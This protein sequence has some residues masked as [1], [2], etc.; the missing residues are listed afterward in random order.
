MDT[1]T[2]PV[3][4]QIGD[5]VI[6]LQGTEL[7]SFN[8]ERNAWAS[9]EEERVTAEAAKAAEKAELL[10]RLGITADEATLLLG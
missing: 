3:F 10:T 4:I 6:E 5:E 8:A 9:A 7:E 2:N 1:T